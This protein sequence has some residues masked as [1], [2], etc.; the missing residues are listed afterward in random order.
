MAL[1]FGEYRE[2][3]DIDLLVSDHAHYG[4]L[5][6]LL[7]NRKDLAPI[8]RRGSMLDV[9]KEVRADS[10]GIRT[11]VRCAGSVIKLEIVYET[12]VALDAPSEVPHEGARLG[13]A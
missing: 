12:R 11:A 10:Y 13:A 1:R 6:A 2:S 4:E 8:V 7:R 9:T 5:R 3:L